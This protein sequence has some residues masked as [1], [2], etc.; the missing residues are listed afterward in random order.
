MARSRRVSN[1]FDHR[2]KNASKVR[3]DRI[4]DE[5]DLRELTDTD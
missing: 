5:I 3:R 4:R 1:R 2:Q